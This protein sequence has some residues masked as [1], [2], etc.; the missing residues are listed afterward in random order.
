MKIKQKKSM[1]NDKFICDK[2][3]LFLINFSL[4]FTAQTRLIF[5]ITSANKLMIRWFVFEAMDW[6]SCFETLLVVQ[7]HGN[8]CI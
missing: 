4:V 6:C 8:I 3:T 1:F 2:D 5:K 7:K